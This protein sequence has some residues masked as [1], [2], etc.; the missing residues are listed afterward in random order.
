[1]TRVDGAWLRALADLVDAGDVDVGRVEL[2]PRGVILSIFEPGFL[3]RKEGCHP[4]DLGSPGVHQ[5]DQP[6]QRRGPD[7]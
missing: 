2:N 5:S 6:N 1:M 3:A 7:D 4:G